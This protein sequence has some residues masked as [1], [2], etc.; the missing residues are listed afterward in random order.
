MTTNSE[1]SLPRDPEMAKSV[2]EY[3]FQHPEFFA[4]RDA[5][6]RELKVPHFSGGAVSL[7]ERQVALLRDENRS[8]NQRL[9]QLLTVAKE[10]EQLAQRVHALAS[11]L[12]DADSLGEMVESLKQEMREGFAASGIALHV[13][14]VPREGVEVP[15][16]VITN[17]LATPQGIHELIAE[18]RSACGRLKPALKE[19]LFPDIDDDKLSA[20]ILPLVN[21]RWQGFFGIAS[22]DTQRFRPEL[23][24]EILTQLAD[25]LTLSLQAW[26]DEPA[27]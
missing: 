3:L 13:H 10:N 23:G 17:P 19:R 18:R 8:L 20:V 16:C 14:A 4:S 26:F 7:V 22:R 25:L 9:D 5:L 27:D 11:H 21:R 2:E 6:L 24:L 12:A 15:D 1:R